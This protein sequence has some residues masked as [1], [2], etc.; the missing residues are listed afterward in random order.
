MMIS[1]FLLARIAEDE[2]VARAASPSPWSY[3]GIETVAGG[4]LYDATRRIVDVAY[5]QSEDHDGQIVRHLLVPEAD[6]NGAHIARHDPARVLAECEA[7][8][9]IVDAA[10][11][12]E[13]GPG[14]P[15]PEDPDGGWALSIALRALAA[16]YADHPDYDEAWQWKR[17][18]GR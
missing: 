3:P 13:E 15:K 8:R 18:A 6:A 7:K 2:E 10:M 11:V 4:T 5:E 1:E 16:I 14:D 17:E 12:Y 9:A